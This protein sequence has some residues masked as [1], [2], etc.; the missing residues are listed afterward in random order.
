MLF[1]YLFCKGTLKLLFGVEPSIF[2]RIIQITEIENCNIIENQHSSIVAVGDRYIKK[3]KKTSF[4]LNILA[5]NLN[6]LK[7]TS[8]A[9]GRVLLQDKLP[10]DYTVTALILI[11]CINSTLI[12]KE[13]SLVNV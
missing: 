2:D 4:Q 5:F 10:S 7:Q 6:N 12:K 11:A 8:F 1:Y 3:D 13:L 9:V